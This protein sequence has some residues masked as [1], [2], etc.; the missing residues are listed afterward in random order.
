MVR[1]GVPVVEMR[2]VTAGRALS[3]ERW[4]ELMASAPPVDPDFAREVE[5]ARE[6]FGPPAGAWPS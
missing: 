4:R 5:D 6:D 3:A 2:P 1:N